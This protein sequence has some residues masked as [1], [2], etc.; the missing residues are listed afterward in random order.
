MVTSTSSVA[1]KKT[2]TDKHTDNKKW[3]VEQIFS[4]YNKE[5]QMDVIC[6]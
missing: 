2:L 6:N 3:V 4:C 1:Q 5:K